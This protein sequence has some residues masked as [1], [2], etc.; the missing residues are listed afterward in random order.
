MSGDEI[1]REI[2]AIDRRLRLA[3]DLR[4]EL[5]RRKLERLGIRT[6]PRTANRLGP[7]IDAARGTFIH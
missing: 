5:E 4:R 2:A 6:K 3:D 1:D 7:A